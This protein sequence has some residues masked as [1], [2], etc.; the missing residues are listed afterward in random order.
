MTPKI[1]WRG[2]LDEEIIL[3][4]IPILAPKSA[5]SRAF[6]WYRYEKDFRNASARNERLRDFKK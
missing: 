6:D 5:N 1:P 4:H 3:P 2:P